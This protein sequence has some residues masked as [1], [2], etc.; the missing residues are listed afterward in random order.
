[1]LIASLITLPDNTGQS[2]QLKLK[3]MNEMIN[4]NFIKYNNKN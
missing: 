3:L 4:N 1:L 2:T